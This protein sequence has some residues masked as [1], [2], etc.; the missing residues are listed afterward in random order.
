MIPDCLDLTQFADH[1]KPGCRVFVFGAVNSADFKLLGIQLLAPVFDLIGFQ[2]A[3]LV[4][5][6]GKQGDDA[7]DS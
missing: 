4:A 1:K 6:I 3:A 2:I 5:G 7:F